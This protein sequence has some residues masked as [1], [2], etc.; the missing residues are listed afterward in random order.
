LCARVGGTLV[1]IVLAQKPVVSSG[2]CTQ[3]AIQ[4][5]NALSAILARCVGALI[6]LLFAQVALETTRTDASERTWLNRSRNA[7]LDALSAV[8]AN[9]L[10]AFVCVNFAGRVNV[11]FESRE[12]VTSETTCDV[13]AFCLVSRAWIRSTAIQIDFTVDTTETGVA[14]ALVEADTIH[15]VT[16]I[17]ARDGGT[18]VYV[19]AIGPGILTDVAVV[20]VAYGGNITGTTARGI[21]RAFGLLS[22][23]AHAVSF[24][25]TVHAS[26]SRRA[27][28]RVQVDH[29]D[30]VGSPLAR[31]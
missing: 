15:T 9:V 12:A 18:L 24:E 13:N 6:N 8:Q 14:G 31:K 19:G 16:V 28:A 3:E 22:F 21:L 17:A 1:Y 2:A 29:V 25:N 20:T 11:S 30:A 5:V 26:V 27:V 4:T 10:S 7:G 23:R